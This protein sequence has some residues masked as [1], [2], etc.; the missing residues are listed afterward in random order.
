MRITVATYHLLDMLVRMTVATIYILNIILLEMFS[1]LM[2]TVILR[3]G[4]YY[5]FYKGE[6]EAQ[7]GDLLKHR[8]LLCS[9]VCA[10]CTYLPHYLAF[11]PRKQF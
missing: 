3:S 5:P 6:T 7:R 2:H 10:P 8:H 9:T 1:G 4:S 11:L